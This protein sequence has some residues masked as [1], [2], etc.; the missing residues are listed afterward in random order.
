MR[1]KGFT[2]I[3]LMIV[4]SIVGILSAVTVPKL[5]FFKK[6]SK[7]EQLKANIVTVKSFLNERKEPTIKAPSTLAT[8]TKDAMT[9]VFSGSRAMKNP[10]TNSN[11]IYYAGE[12]IGTGYFSNLTLNNNNIEASVLIFYVGGT[13][14]NSGTTF[15]SNAPLPVTENTVSYFNRFSA[16]SLKNHAGKVLI[17]VHYDGF[18]GFGVNDEGEMLEPFVLKFTN[19]NDYKLGA[20]KPSPVSDLDIIQE[21]IIDYLFKR[22]KDDIRFIQRENGN[23]EKTIM[24]YLYNNFPTSVE[25]SF[26]VRYS[27]AKTQ[28]VTSNGWKKVDTNKIFLLFEQDQFFTPDDKSAYRNTLC[29]IPNIK[30][31]PPGYIVYIIDADGKITKQVNVY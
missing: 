12:I 14:S 13:L 28:L 16:S 20:V 25:N 21:E 1:K 24:N 27:A 11:V 17:I 9:S 10:F 18:V 8:L 19:I 6:E 29:V 4:I 30:G 31:N 22:V 15:N 3:E 26:A 23:D 2:L 5:N 7:M